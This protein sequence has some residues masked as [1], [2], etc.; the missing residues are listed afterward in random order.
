MYVVSPADDVDHVFALVV[1]P[2]DSP[3]ARSPALPVLRIITVKGPT[4]LRCGAPQEKAKWREKDKQSWETRIRKSD[5]YLTRKSVVLNVY[6]SSTVLSPKTVIASLC[7]TLR[8]L[9]TKRS[10]RTGQVNV[11]CFPFIQLKSR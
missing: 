6:T 2:I 4:T 7:D 3:V 8:S 10:R 9:Q 1:A 5:I 11:C